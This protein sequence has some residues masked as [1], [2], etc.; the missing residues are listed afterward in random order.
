M[1]ALIYNSGLG[2]RMGELTAH[3]HKSMV[4]LQ[5]GETIFER[6]IR[7]LQECGI[8]DV[9]V[10]TGPFKEQ[11]EQVTKQPRFSNMHF[12]LVEN[13]VYDQTNYIY[14]MYLAKEHIND[15][16]ILLHGDLVFNKELLKKVLA[17]NEANLITIN[18][19]KTLP[20]KDFKGRIKDGK[21]QEV[22]IN[23]FDDNCFALQPMY[24]LDRETLSKWVQKTVEFVESGNTK[25]YA[26]NAFNEILPTLDVKEFS[27][28]NDYIDEIDNPDDLKRVSSEIRS[29]DFREQP[30]YDGLESLKKILDEVNPTKIMVVSDKVM[31][32]KWPLKSLLDNLGVDYT[33]FCDYESNPQFNDIVKGIKM[34]KD[35]KCDF[36]ISLGGGSSIDTA[37]VMKLYSVLDYQKGVTNDYKYNPIK[38]LAIPTTAGTGSESTR[39]AVC[40]YEGKKQSVTH[41]SI[42][43]DYV[44][45]EPELLMGLPLYQKKATIL[46]AL[47]QSIESYWSVNS[48]DESKEY[49]KRSIK[50]ILNELEG[51]INDNNL[52]ITAKM[53]HASNLAG[54]AI[55]ITQTTAAHAMSYKLTSLYGIAHGHAVALTLPYVW[56]YMINNTDKCIDPRGKDY[57][58]D[59]FNELANIFECNSP[60][61]CCN[62]LKEVFNN[63]DLPIPESTNEELDMLTSSVNP[64]RLRN[65]PVE[66][67]K[68]TITDIYTKSLYI[69]SESKNNGK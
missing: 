58:N 5:N 8:R 41:D 24:K 33:F 55:N 37:K 28:E 36:I 35:E 9:V 69:F 11:L 46:D 60:Q 48:T 43:P 54:K 51:Y 62:K 7:I 31:F 4:K 12:T 39:Y 52:E 45:L 65:N 61:M 29:F 20:E 66:L 13:S 10:T 47:A 38:H 34:L 18:R 50:S 15:D 22:S 42:V 25:V 3:C 53:L 56:E 57:L 32:D 16:M 6:Q 19:Q 1:K 49:S 67:D 14:S 63:F 64:D 26:E 23:I 44:I 68:Q 21:L 30:I 59:A 27:Y 40:Y 17:S 2:K